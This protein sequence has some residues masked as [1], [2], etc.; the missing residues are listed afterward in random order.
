MIFPNNKVKVDSM[1]FDREGFIWI[2]LNNGTLIVY[3]NTNRY[4]SQTPK[5]DPKGKVN[6]YYTKEVQRM[7]LSVILSSLHVDAKVLA[8]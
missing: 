3:Q 5:I 8:F 4:Q 1:K 7:E 6:L 2:I